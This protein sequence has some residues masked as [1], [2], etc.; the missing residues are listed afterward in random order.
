MSILVLSLRL[1]CGEHTGRGFKGLFEVGAE[2]RP[3]LAS[4][5]GDAVR[6]V[7]SASLVCGLVLAVEVLKGLSETR[8]H[9][10]LVVQSNGFL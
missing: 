6:L 9:A 3:C 10:V 8:R 7:N 4:L 2:A 5:V 1:I